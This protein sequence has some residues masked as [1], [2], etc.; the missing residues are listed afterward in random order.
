MLLQPALAKAIALNARLWVKD[1]T[2]NVAGSHKARHLMGV[3]L[4]LRVLEVAK[5]PAAETLR[6]RRLAIASCGNAALAAAVVAQASEWPL[7]AYIPADANLSV[8]TQLKTLGATINVCERRPGEAG[9]P[10]MRAFRQA[11]R[12]GAIPFSVQGPETAWRSKADELWRLKWRKLSLPVGTPNTIFIQVGGGALASAV[13]QGLA[14][15]TR[16][17]AI[18]NIPRLMLVQTAGCAPFARCWQHLSGVEPLMQ[19]NIA[20]ALCGRGLALSPARRPEF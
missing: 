20:P 18:A 8:V 2:G 9:D 13:W 10:C 5:Q 19:C 15:A 16:A 7:D 1:E 3:M 4:Y 6:T 14:M 11:V 17:S 12:S